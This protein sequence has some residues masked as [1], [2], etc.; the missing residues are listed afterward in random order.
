MKKL[1][2]INAFKNCIAEIDITKVTDVKKIKYNSYTLIYDVNVYGFYFF[3][4]D[5]IIFTNTLSELNVT[6]DKRFNYTN[7]NIF[8]KHFFGTNIIIDDIF[9]FGVEVEENLNYLYS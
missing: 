2:I 7:L 8:L 5:R 9:K 3:Y 1:Q 4:K 6:L